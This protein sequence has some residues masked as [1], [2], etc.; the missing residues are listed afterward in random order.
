MPIGQSAVLADLDVVPAEIQS[1]IGME[2]IDVE[3]LKPCT[4]SSRLIKR[5]EIISGYSDLKYMDIWIYSFE[6]GS[7]QAIVC[8]NRLR[9]ENE[10]YK[11]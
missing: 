1:L 8:K 11:T 10:L 4:V 5:M 2:I 6:N 3:Y 7:K 9:N